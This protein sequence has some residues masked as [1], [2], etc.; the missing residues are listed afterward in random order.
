VEKINIDKKDVKNIKIDKR[1]NAVIVSVNPSIYPLEVVYSAA[2]MFL[3]KVYV[4]IDGNTDKEIFVKL[5]PKLKPKNKGKYL[6][7]LAGLFNNELVNYSVYVIQAARSSSIRDAI[8]RVALAVEKTEET[9]EESEE[10]SEE[11]K[12]FVEDPLGIAK[13]WTPEKAKGIKAPEEIKNLL[14][15]KNDKSKQER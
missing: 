7:E 5:K 1:D 14:E 11:E 2:Y 8:I 13:P 6:E 10:E 3:D 15:E 12:S 9:E 4:F